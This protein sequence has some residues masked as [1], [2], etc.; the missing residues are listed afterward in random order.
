[1]CCQRIWNAL[2][3]VITD[4]SDQKYTIPK[5]YTHALSETQLNILGD[6][7]AMRIQAFCLA[8]N[9]IFSLLLDYDINILFWLVN[10]FWIIYP[11][12]IVRSN[13]AHFGRGLSILIKLKFGRKIKSIGTSSVIQHQIRNDDTLKVQKKM[14]N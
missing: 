7:H 12:F 3:L 10:A 6:F 2:Y 8:A 11:S 14:W 5:L 4:L 9:F 1:M 13:T